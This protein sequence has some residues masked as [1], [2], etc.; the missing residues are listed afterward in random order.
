MADI[1][2]TNV[3][4]AVVQNLKRPQSFL[5]DR[6]FPNV[7]TEQSEEI[8]FDLE[9]EDI[10]LAPFV[11]PL[12]A[13][14]VMAQQG[15]TTKTFK[16]AYLKPKTPLDPN[17]PLKRAMGEQI[18]GGQYSPMQRQEM[19]LNQELRSHIGRITRR[20][21][22]MASSALR[23]GA[24]NVSGENYPTVNVDFGRDANNTV[25]LTGGSQWGDAGVNP[26]DDLQD[27]SDQLL[28]ASGAGGFD[29]VMSVDVWKVFRS[30]ANVKDRLDTRRVMDNGMNL[31]AQ[32]VEGGVYRGT[33]DGFN[34]FTYAGSYK[35]ESGTVQKILP[36][37][38]VIVSSEAV[39]GYRAFGAIRDE[40]AGYQAV[41]YFAKSWVEKDP[42]VRYLLTQSAPLVVP[43][44]VNASFCANSVVA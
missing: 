25:T 12:V 42:S 2:S 8:H 24:V 34:I 39:M 22:V 30:D 6:F 35:D 29:V 44:R 23:T 13:G 33:I 20:L 16:P 19:A 36:D 9:D 38:T 28:L 14:K 43:Y 32:Q 27:W 41:E 4:A 40:E 31:G 7:Q 5:L 1:Y 15:F 10:S 17:R 18:G 11:S 37:G 26:L 21:E 3:L